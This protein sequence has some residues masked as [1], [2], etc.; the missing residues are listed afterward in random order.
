MITMH[1]PPRQTDTD[2]QTDRW[3]DERTSWQYRDDSF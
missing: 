3:M 2:G 1:G